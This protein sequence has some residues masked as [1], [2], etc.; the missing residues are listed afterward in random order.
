ME[1]NL[2]NCTLKYCI[3]NRDH[4]IAFSDIENE[5]DIEYVLAISMWKGDEIKLIE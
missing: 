5:N 3:N 4:G 1:L 2:Q